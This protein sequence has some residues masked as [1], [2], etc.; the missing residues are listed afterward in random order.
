VAL[1]GRWCLRYR[2]AVEWEALSR[3]V[4]R[5]VPALAGIGRHPALW[6]VLGSLRAATALRPSIA[7]IVG[8]VRGGT[9]RYTTRAGCTIL[10]RHQTRDV[11]LV[12]E[13]MGHLHAYD[14]PSELHNDLSGPL[15]IL[16][17]GGN[18][19]MFGAFA[20]GRWQVASIR[21][22]EPDPAN[23]ELLTATIAANHAQDRWTVTRAAV[24]NQP[25][26]MRFLPGRLAES[27]EALDHE[28][29]GIEVQAIDVLALTAH[30]DLLKIDIEG[31]E[32][33]ILSD[34]RMKA[35]DVKVLVM[36]W[37]RLRSP[38]PDPAHV[39][40]QLL[41]EVGY[42]IVADRP[43]LIALSTG[44]VWARRPG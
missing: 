37:H 23:A 4:V 3:R 39:A 2:D 43:D 41:R 26:T 10:V 31:G 36:E 25:G 27:R 1:S 15:A 11:A 29:G 38:G 44:V 16:D 7:F 17:L 9:R 18:T 12:N 42:E 40:H 24:S 30:I 19:G 13:I 35:L 14:P 21:S 32:W 34:P 22:F 8:E 20:L 28:T 5:H 33:A 6:R